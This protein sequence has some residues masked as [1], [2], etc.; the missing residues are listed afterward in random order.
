MF[1]I[2]KEDKEC[3]DMC[4]RNH[5]LSGTTQT[6]GYILPCNEA[7]KYAAFKQREKHRKDVGG[8]LFC[9]IM[10]CGILATTL[11]AIF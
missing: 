8:F 10:V 4:S 9:L 7:Q 6:I 5:H 3:M 1:Y 2:S 11:V